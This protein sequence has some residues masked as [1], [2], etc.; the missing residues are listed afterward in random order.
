MKKHIVLLV[1]LSIGSTIFAQVSTTRSVSVKRTRIQTEYQ[2]FVRFGAGALDLGRSENTYGRRSTM[3]FGGVINWGFRKPFNNSNLSVYW[4]MEYGLA[5]YSTTLHGNYNERYYQIYTSDGQQR[6]L[7]NGQYDHPFFSV[8]THA[9]NARPF[10]LGLDFKV[11]PD[12]SVDLH[13]GVG[14]NMTLF[15]RYIYDNGDSFNMK[16]GDG[17]I[18]LRKNEG[19]NKRLYCDIQAGLGVWW[20]KLNLEV[21]AVAVPRNIELNADVP[22]EYVSYNQYGSN[23]QN[24]TGIVHIDAEEYFVIQLLVRLGIAF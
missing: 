10:M 19:M 6:E 17:T 20:K 8:Y 9:L 23:P 12:I 22:Y 1:L 16:H 2:Y 24:Y 15:G 7:P 11:A 18:S 14:L 21:T 13:A 5:P 3:P 4:G